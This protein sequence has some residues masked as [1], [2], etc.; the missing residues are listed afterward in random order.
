MRGGRKRGGG[1]RGVGCT[2]E[3]RIRWSVLEVSPKTIVGHVFLQLPASVHVPA[4]TS[5][6]M[7]GLP[8]TK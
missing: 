8:R 5:R 6:G 1:K 7:R 2:A 4:E 3:R